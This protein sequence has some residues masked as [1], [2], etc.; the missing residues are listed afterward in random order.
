MG[1][2]PQTTGPD[3]EPVVAGQF[4]PGDATALERQV[5][6]YLQRGRSLEPLGKV[7]LAMAPHAGY[8]FSGGVAGETLGRA[9]LPKTILLLGPN[10]TG[11]G[12]RFSLWPGG[13]WL[14]PGGAVTVDEDLTQA[15][16]KADPAV[17]LDVEA[18]LHEHSL[19]V[20]LPFLRGMDPDTRVAALAVS[21]PNLDALIRVGK[22]LA[23]VIKQ[24]PQDVAMVVSSDMSHYVSQAT[25]EEL[26]S[27]A[28][29]R[30]QALDPEGLL[31]TVRSRNISM[32]GVLPMTVGLSACRE[33][34]ATRAEVVS[35]ATSGNASGDYSRVVGYAGAL[36]S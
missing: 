1:G 31:Q 13:R 12:A 32:C 16:D 22:A 30:V 3:R 10:H 25:A 23:E 28:L 29:D 7:M 14:I 9:E 20:M 6:E 15:L 35:Y 26:D 34:G 4:Y 27:Q 11:R 24:W 2:P 18:H 5:D 21:E 36:V 19:E 33:L 17:T 8:V